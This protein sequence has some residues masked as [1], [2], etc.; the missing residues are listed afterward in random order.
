EVIARQS[1][2]KR[3]IDIYDPNPPEPA[4]PA[5]PRIDTVASG[6]SAPGVARLVW[7]TPDDGGSP[8]TGYNV[9]RGLT[10]GFETLIGAVGVQNTY[11]D[12]TADPGTTFYYQF[13]AVNVTG[14]GGA[15][16]EFLVPG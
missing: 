15:C 7:S 10:S 4:P 11:D 6:R 2:G 12:I 9:Y 8:I 16:R 14:T 3:L 13:R 5:P 1:G